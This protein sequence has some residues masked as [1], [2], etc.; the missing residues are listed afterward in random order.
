VKNGDSLNKTFL[1]RIRGKNVFLPFEYL[2]V[3]NCNGHEVKWVIDEIN[4]VKSYEDLENTALFKL[5]MIFNNRNVDNDI[6]SIY[7]TNW[8][9][10]NEILEG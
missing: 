4:N 9:L 2:S 3:I 1:D 6:Y 5:N 10:I 7:D 8:Y